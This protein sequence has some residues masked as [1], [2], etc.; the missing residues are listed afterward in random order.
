M[1]RTAP[2]ST[3]SPG[4]ALSR[5]MLVNVKRDQTAET[6]RV[7]WAHEFPILEAIHG[8]GNIKPVEA[9]TLD[10]HFTAKV[11][12]EMLVHNK[13]QDAIVPPSESMG[14]GFVFVGD[15]KVEYERLVNVY[16]RHPDIAVSMTEHV[17]GRFQDGKFERVLGR[18]EVEDLPAG[19]LRELI[20]SYGGA[21]QQTSYQASAEEKAA[22]VAEHAAFRN[23][24]REDLLKQAEALGVEL[25]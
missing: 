19:Q 16:G 25:A 5:R 6:P 20:A 9:A 22:A 1:A 2:A 17:Y 14:L 18:A 21:P 15:P 12:P 3:P 13:R 10:E 7:I 11:S 4:R 24:Q 23:A 8:E